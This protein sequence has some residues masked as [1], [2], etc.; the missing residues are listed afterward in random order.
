MIAIAWPFKYYEIVTKKRLM[1]VLCT[2]WILPV[3]VVIVPPFIFFNDYKTFA[4]FKDRLYACTTR[5]FN[6]TYPEIQKYLDYVLTVSVVFYG[7][8]V[9]VI[10][11]SYT[12]ILRISLHHIRQINLQE[13]VSVASRIDD[14]LL[15]ASST[16]NEGYLS[17]SKRKSLQLPQYTSRTPEKVPADERRLSQHKNLDKLCMTRKEKDVFARIK[18]EASHPSNGPN[19]EFSH[20]ES[21]TNCDVPH[22]NIQQDGLPAGNEECLRQLD[23]ESGSVA[24]VPQISIK[25]FNQE[26]VNATAITGTNLSIT[27]NMCLQLPG[28]ELGTAVEAPRRNS[29]TIIQQKVKEQFRKKKKEIRAA[30]TLGGLLIA[31]ILC[32][33]PLVGVT[34]HNST[35]SKAP[36]KQIFAT[37]RGLLALAFLHSSV[38]P[39]IYCLRIAEFKVSVKNTLKRIAKVCSRS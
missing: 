11:I 30:K 16:L 32:Y 22:I 24:E 15:V 12:I 36:S 8:P 18:T 23:S 38:N 10:V 7:I 19:H 14:D 29:F 39:L 34:W 4:L 25:K 13:E 21:A 28:S 33:T 27:K 26:E 31:F 20:S 6:G 9:L 35:T 37:T 2:A 5:T 1:F 17:Q 3:L